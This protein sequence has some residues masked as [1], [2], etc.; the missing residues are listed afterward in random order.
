MFRIFGVQQEDVQPSPEAFMSF[1]HPEDREYARDVTQRALKSLQDSLLYFRLQLHNGQV[2]YAYSE[3][4]FEFN[5]EGMP[6]RMYGII[7]DTTERT[8]AEANLKA[9][10]KELETFIYRAAHDLRGPLSSVMGMVTIGKQEIKDEYALRM[11]SMIGESAQ[12]LDKTLAGLVQ[13]MYIKDTK[14]FADKINFEQLFSESIEKY[15]HAQGFSRMEFKVD[16]SSTRNYVSNRVILESVVQNMIENAIKYQ[17]YNRRASLH[18][19]V[20][21]NR[22]EHKLVFA[23]SGT[24]IHPDHIN[25]V[26]DMYFRGVQT[27]GGS[28]LGL[29]IVKTGI[30]KL[31]GR[32]E[33]KSEYGAGTT[34]TIYLPS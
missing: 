13:S 28:G 21:D 15:S 12:K 29:Y 8:R 1:I 27:T 3:W 22:Y 16:I 26:F 30:E 11:F 34:F 31:R 7:Q 23:D 9:V 32:I 2:K 14:S 25:Q 5:A 20:S 19:S 33:V 18:I 24:G 4:K 6:L 17:N 10:N